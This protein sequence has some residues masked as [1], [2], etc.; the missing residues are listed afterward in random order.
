MIK[1]LYDKIGDREEPRIKEIFRYWIRNDHYSEETINLADCD[2][3]RIRESRDNG[4][5]IDFDISNLKNKDRVE[6][7]VNNGLRP[8]ESAALRNMRVKEGLGLLGG[9]V[10]GEGPRLLIAVLSTD[11]DPCHGLK[12]GLYEIACYSECGTNKKRVEEA[13]HQM[14]SP[15]KKGVFSQE[16]VTK[17][18]REHRGCM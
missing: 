9:K 14:I 2:I 6:C 1:Q 10:G 16:Y 18:K 13:I 12:S 5:Y 4:N 8:Y 15:M 11:A 3:L 7:I 17:W